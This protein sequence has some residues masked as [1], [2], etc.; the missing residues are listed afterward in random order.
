MILHYRK[1][2]QN[3]TPLTRA[4]M[5]TLTNIELKLDVQLVKFYRRLEHVHT[6]NHQT[7]EFGSE[8]KY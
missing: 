4:D 7:T 2:A 5:C 8:R 1:T 3:S 6:L